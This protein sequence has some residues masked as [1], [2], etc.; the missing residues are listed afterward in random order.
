MVIFLWYS[1]NSNE[2][3]ATLSFMSDTQVIV[4]MLVFYLVFFNFESSKALLSII[5]PDEERL[6]YLIDNI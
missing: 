6:E 2:S 1:H 3:F 5:V 4:F